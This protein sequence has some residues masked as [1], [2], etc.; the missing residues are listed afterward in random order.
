[1]GV[2]LVCRNK[3]HKQQMCPGVSYNLHRIEQYSVDNKQFDAGFCYQHFV[4]A[5]SIKHFIV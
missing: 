5:N 2:G 4:E 1:M 3:Y